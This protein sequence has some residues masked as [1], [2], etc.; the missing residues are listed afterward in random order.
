MAQLPFSQIDVFA[1]SDYRG[2][3][4]AVVHSADSLSDEQ[5][6]AFARWTNL[7]ETTFLLT[8]KRPEADYRLRIFTP[9]GELPF[10]GHPTLGSC[11][12]W[13]Q[14]GGVP[15]NTGVVL[16]ECDAGLITVRQLAGKLAFAAPPLLRTG[17]LDPSLRTQ[18]CEALELPQAAVVADQWIDNGPGWCALLLDSAERVLSCQLDPAL[19]GRTPFGVIGPNLDG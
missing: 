2:N 10:A 11:F 5:M 6:A 1:A 9:G 18:L 15:K 16:Q 17:A 8:P 19:A 12:A 13:L 14:S 7:S 3:P 4:V